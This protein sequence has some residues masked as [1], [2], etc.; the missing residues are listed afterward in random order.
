MTA[1]ALVHGAWHGGWVWRRVARILRDAGH[2]VITPTLTGCGERV[3]LAGNH[4]NLSLHVTDVQNAIRWEDL[5]DY[6]LV[7]HSYGCAVVSA[8]ADRDAAQMRALVCIDGFMPRDGEAVWDYTKPK[9][10]Y[11]VDGAGKNGGRTEPIPSEEFGINPEDLDW[12][13]SK[14]VPMSIACFMEQIDLSGALENI[15]TK[16]YVHCSGWGPSPFGAI[17]DQLAETPG[18][19]VHRIECGH[20]RMIDEPETCAS[21]LAGF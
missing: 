20:H 3:H 7:G 2:D 11:F 5:E 21:F 17:H 8:V 14:V 10:P 4:V 18:W 9:H 1:F 15:P 16:A 12:V 19:Q 13:K 6:V